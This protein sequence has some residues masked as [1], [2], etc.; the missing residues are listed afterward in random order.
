MQKQTE[1]SKIYEQRRQ[2][3][4]VEINKDK[5]KSA[6]EK[7]RSKIMIEEEV[8]FEKHLDDQEEGEIIEP[9]KSKSKDNLPSFQEYATHIKPLLLTRSKLEDLLNLPRFDE[10]VSGCF[11]RYQ[12]NKS[13]EYTVAQILSVVESNSKQYKIGNTETNLLLKVQIAA[14]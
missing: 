10:F 5:L 14:N 7:L 11:I 4:K 8:D 6:T 12:C 13:N 9:G 1:L 2:K 3:K